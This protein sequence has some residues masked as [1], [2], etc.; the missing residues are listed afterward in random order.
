MLDHKDL[1]AI[2]DQLDLKVSKEQKE[3]SEKMDLWE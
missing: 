1:M 2:G 3:I